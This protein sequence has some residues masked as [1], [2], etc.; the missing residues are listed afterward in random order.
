MY[1]CYILYIYIYIIYIF[2]YINIYIIYIYIYIYVYIYIQIYI[3][4]HIWVSPSGQKRFLIKIVPN[5]EI[6]KEIC[7]NV[8]QSNQSFRATVH[9]I[10]TYSILVFD[11]YVL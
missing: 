6:K 10:V 9:R 7:F 11:I 4:I 3:Y 5:K 2:I 1:I 8:S